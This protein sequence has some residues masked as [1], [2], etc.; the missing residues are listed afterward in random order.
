MAGLP[1]Y[2]VC[3]TEYRCGKCG[4]SLEV[5]WSELDG[6]KPVEAVVVCPLA[7]CRGEARPVRDNY[8]VDFRRLGER[9]ERIE[10]LMRPPITI[11]VEG[12]QI[13][14][15]GGLQA[16]VRYR[17]PVR[18]GVLETLSRGPARYT[19]LRRGL[20]TSDPSLQG[21]LRAL[22]GSGLIVKGASRRGLYEITQEGRRV[23]DEAFELES[24]TQTDDPDS[25][26]TTRERSLVLT[27]PTPD[28][29]T[30][31]DEEPAGQATTSG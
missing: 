2:R 29:L 24:K 8:M 6:G 7:S 11:A 20:G 14:A 15:T 31:R 5:R 28:A 26:P 9:L 1:F 23:Y 10:R 12:S 3:S 19:E 22:L 21:A 16:L 17:S 4:T 25:A 18:F 27:P 30:E 13:A